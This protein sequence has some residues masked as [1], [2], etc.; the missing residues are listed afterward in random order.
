MLH[1]IHCATKGGM[2]MSKNEVRSY[3]ASVKDYVNL[4]AVCRE[5]GI[6]K[7]ALHQFMKDECNNDHV[8]QEK[9]NRIVEFIQQL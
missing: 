5:I 8:S 3:I 4:S 7:Q 1:N 9:L 6:S 2:C